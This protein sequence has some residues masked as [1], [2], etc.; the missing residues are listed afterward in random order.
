MACRQHHKVLDLSSEQRI[1]C[2]EKRVE[3]HIYRAR[4]RSYDGRSEGVLGLTR[5]NG[6]TYRG[7]EFLLHSLSHENPPFLGLCQLPPATDIAGRGS[8]R[9]HAAGHM[10]PK[11]PHWR[12][13]CA[14]T[15]VNRAQC[16]G[17]NRSP[18]RALRGRTRSH[19]ISFAGLLGAGVI[20][21]AKTRAGT[22]RY[23]LAPRQ[24]SD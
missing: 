8:P 4:K 10:P 23:R 3:A 18:H 24:H 9:M 19:E 22:S 20:K 5:P 14:P 6:F 12:D 13:R 16:V 17:V 2:D 21:P 15:R 1:R 7:T 11:Q